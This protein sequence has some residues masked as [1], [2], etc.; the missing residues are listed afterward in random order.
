MLRLLRD[1]IDRAAYQRENAALRDA[2]RPLSAVRDGKVLLETL[3]T[4]IERYG[5][6]GRALPLESLRKALRQE[7]RRTRQA[8]T[9]VIARQRKLLDDAHG[10]I[11][12][13]RVRRKGWS[14]LGSGVTRTYQH[15]RNAM[16]LAQSHSAKDLHE[17]RKQVKYLRHQLEVLEPISGMISE[18]A[19]QSHRLSD[20]LGDDHDLMILREKITGK[21][22]RVTD[23]ET[24]GALLAL[25]DRCRERLQ[26]KAFVSGAR[27]FEETPKRFKQRL[28]Q[29][30][31]AWRTGV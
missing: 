28:G 21:E 3:D 19:D 20:Y 12:R 18:L 27:I 13:W 15:A 7:H 4:L 6:A 17:W 5:P 11:A 24:H 29:Y 23:K 10:R 22:K 25:I 1:S 31:R 30:W 14:V 8:L 16:T 2:A 26:D 9:Q